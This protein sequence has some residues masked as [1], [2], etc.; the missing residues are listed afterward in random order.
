MQERPNA[1]FL[2]R[3]RAKRG[4][5]GECRPQWCG[6]QDLGVSTQLEQPTSSAVKTVLDELELRLVDD[7]YVKWRTNASAHPRN[8]TAARKTYDTGLVLLLDLFT[9]AVSTAGPPVAEFARFEYGLSHVVALVAFGSMYQFGQ[10]FGG[11][12]FPPYS[13]AFGRKSVYISASLIY[14]ISCIIVGFTPSVAGA[15]V[16]RFIS[17]F[18]S[19]VPSIIVSG[20]I[21]DMFNMKERVWLIYIWA[22]A[23]TGGL[24]VGPIYGSYL[25][26]TVGWRWVFYIASIVMAFFTFLL[27]F[28]KESRASRL[29]A[30]RLEILHERTGLTHFRINNPDHTPS[31]QTFARVALRRPVQLF[32]TDP[33]VFVVSIMSAVGWALIYLFTQAIPVICQGFGLSRE[34]SS[35]LFLAILVGIFF[36]IFPRIYDHGVLKKRSDADSPLHPEDKLMGFAFAAP[37]LAFG[38]WWLVLTV[39]PASNLPWYATIVGLI[40]IGF[41]TNEF[42]CTLSGYLADTYTIYASSAFAAMSFLRAVLGGLFPLIGEPMYTALGSNWA[43]VILACI[44]T[45]FCATPVLFMKFGRRIRQKSKFAK[46]SLRVNRET[47]IQ[48]DNVE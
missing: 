34:Q 37:S 5:L 32:F 8:W 35:L 7:D 27:S 44:A 41:A 17:G 24:L 14:C 4:Y 42:A 40:P 20:S 15:V 13:E 30:R 33:I 2:N 23:T 39:P 22:C 28:I 26:A 12:I 1:A 9:T 36:G 11:V 25:A 21:E 6:G 29:L 16:G 47:Q 48:D 31:F 19:A 43:T 46:Y 38:L 45:I 3:N 10:A 18:T